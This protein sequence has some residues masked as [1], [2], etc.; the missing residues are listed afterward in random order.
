LV[1]RLIPITSSTGVEAKERNA[2]SALLAVLSHVDEFGRTLLKPLGAP[3]GKIEAFVETAFK[4][5]NGRT[6]RPDGLLGVTRA[7]RT[8]WA[9]VE[10]KIGDQQLTAEQMEAYLDLARA[11]G[12]DAVLSISNHYTTSSSDY[13]IAVDRKKLRKVALHHWSWVRVLTE[14]EV[15][16]QHRGIKDPDQAYIL[17]E[18]IRYLSDPRSG[19]VQFD[20][21]G[22]SWTKVREGARTRTLRRTDADVA[23]IANRWDE[24][25]RFLSLD[26]TKE[27]G[28]DVRQL[29][30]RQEALAADRAQ[31]LRRSFAEQGRLYADLE[32]HEHRSH[33]SEGGSVPWPPL[34]ATPSVAEGATRPDRRGPCRPHLPDPQRPARPDP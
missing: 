4:L 20:D 17:D 19:V 6:I 14:A 2:A 33:R 1:A 5:D 34:L 8:W 9:L 28:R 32:I 7:G 24:L 27:L 3:A 22:P 16:K 30:R 23:A 10:C 31:A 11:V 29:A 25:I 26:L 21:M 13:P 12:I 15:Q 18:L